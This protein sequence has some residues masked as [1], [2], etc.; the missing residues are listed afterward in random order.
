MS[1]LPHSS[2]FVDITTGKLLLRF[3]VVTDEL[4]SRLRT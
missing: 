4:G 3:T 1:A 2:L